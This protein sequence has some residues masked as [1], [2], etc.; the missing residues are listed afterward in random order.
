MAAIS[1]VKILHPRRLL[2]I[3]SLVTCAGWVC[4]TREEGGIRKW[5]ELGSPEE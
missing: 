5:R 4:G 2:I 3:H 1:I